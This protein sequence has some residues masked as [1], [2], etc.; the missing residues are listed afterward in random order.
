M[1]CIS[2]DPYTVVTIFLNVIFFFVK[3]NSPSF[4]R[5]FLVRDTT[6]PM[7]CGMESKSKTMVPNPLA[8]DRYRS[9]GQLVPCQR[10]GKKTQL[11]YYF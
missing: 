1:F 2:V 5:A 11:T 6:T 10:G 9:V 3:R 7:L 4:S 8:M